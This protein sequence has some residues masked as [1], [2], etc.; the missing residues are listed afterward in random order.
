MGKVMRLLLRCV[1]F[2]YS[3][4][5]NCDHNSLYFTEALGTAVGQYPAPS[6]DVAILSC[7]HI[8]QAKYV[9][10]MSI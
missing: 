10:D 8:Q 4:Q 1:R 3:F 2:V 6:N 5:S 9:M 7:I